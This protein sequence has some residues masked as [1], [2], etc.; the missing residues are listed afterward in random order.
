MPMDYK[1]YPKNWKAISLA[2]RERDKWRCKFCGVANGELHPITGGKVTLTVAH[3]DNPDPMDVRDENL[4]ALCNRCHI[5]LDS[6]M[7]VQHRAETRY[8]RKIEA[9]QLV[10]WQMEDTG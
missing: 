5:I 3:I 7:H 4:A 8:Q 9:G 10:M 6:A 2:I 1:R